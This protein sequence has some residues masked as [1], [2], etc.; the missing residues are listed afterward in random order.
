MKRVVLLPFFAT[1]LLAALGSPARAQEVPLD[2]QKGV[3]GRVVVA[4][5]LLNKPTPLTPERERPLRGNAAVRRP[6]GREIAPIVEPP[7]ALTIMLEGEGIRTEN[8]EPPKLVVEGMR[9]V[10]SGLVAPRAMAIQ[11]ENRQATAITVVDKGGAVVAK[12]EPGATAD[13]PLRVGQ[14]SLSIQE[15]PF[16]TASVRVLERGRILTLKDG[17]IPLSDIPGGEYT[18]TFF[19]G[20]EPLRIQPLLVPEA[21]LVFIDA[22]VSALKVVEVSIKDAS[23]RVAVPPSGLVPKDDAIP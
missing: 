4:A 15:M 7:P 2:K 22:T 21:G 8:V 13:A 19:F 1:L 11:I 5:E 6:L 17:E 20:A 9:I 16:A 23:M 10:P 12:I 3:R 18:L 14:H